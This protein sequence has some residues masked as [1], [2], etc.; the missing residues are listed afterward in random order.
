MLRNI[1]AAWDTRGS[2]QVV[3]FF[4]VEGQDPTRR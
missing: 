4:A 3:G 1:D 2:R